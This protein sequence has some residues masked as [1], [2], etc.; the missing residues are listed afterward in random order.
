M[1][2]SKRSIDQQGHHWPWA[3]AV[4]RLCHHQCISHISEGDCA[5]ASLLTGWQER[6]GMEP[7]GVL[8][9]WSC[10][11]RKTSSS[12]T[13]E[14][15]WPELDHMLAPWPIQGKGVPY[16]DLGQLWCT[17]AIR[18]FAT[19]ARVGFYSEEK[20][21]TCC[22]NNA[23]RLFPALTLRTSRYIFSAACQ[24]SISSNSNSVCQETKS[25]S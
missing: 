11:I 23:P 6:K 2:D 25:F 4:F 3:L 9:S 1:G 15:N 16:L 7:N 20:R 19:E 5:T 8:S 22:G 12:E 21:D 24:P 14:S 13:P 17:L 10:F 18:A